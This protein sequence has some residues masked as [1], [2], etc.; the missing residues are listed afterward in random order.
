MYPCP[1]GTS[2]DQVVKEHLRVSPINP[3]NLIQLVNTTLFRR[4]RGEVNQLIEQI[5]GQ[6]W[7]R[8]SSI[9]HRII[10][11]NTPSKQKQVITSL[12]KFQGRV[13]VKSGPTHGL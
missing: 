2:I 10:E 1:A 11:S 3:I 5:A 12:T 4:K 13:K 6:N 9:K 7:H 8:V